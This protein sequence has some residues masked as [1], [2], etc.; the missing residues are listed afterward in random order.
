VG[1]ARA[2]ERRGVAMRRSIVMAGAGA[3]A[4]AGAVLVSTVGRWRSWGVDLEASD[5][6]LP[7]DELVPDATTVDSR[8]IEIDAPP[9]S[10]WPW[11]VQMGDDRGGLYSYSVMGFPHRGGA[12]TIM[13]EWQT[14]ATGD[15]INE[16][17]V[18]ELEPERALVL[19]SDL[20]G[21]W[22]WVFILEPFDGGTR[23]RL[24]ER[25]RGRMAGVPERLRALQAPFDLAELV[26]IR[27]QMLGI[28]ER[29]ER[30]A[31]TARPV[32]P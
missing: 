29:A 13:P 7:G 18:R 1:L 24:V 5:A 17:V 12:D 28:R 15:I 19:Y 16:W 25:W 21:S 11:L 32:L 14:L 31:R 30:I 10:V 3:V 2:V 27:K 4:A 20:A 6:T 23:T 22:S 8:F 26:M 9:S